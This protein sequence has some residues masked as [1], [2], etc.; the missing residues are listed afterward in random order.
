MTR[1]ELLQ[2]LDDALTFD[3]IAERLEGLG[4]DSGDALDL[5]DVTHCVRKLM[6][7][8]VEMTDEEFDELTARKRDNR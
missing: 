4:Y 1:L 5:G 3:R 2:R 8:A 6:R 7:Q